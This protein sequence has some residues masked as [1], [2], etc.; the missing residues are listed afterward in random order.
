MVPE[1]I[2]LGHIVSDNGIQVDKLK[3]EVINKLPFTTNQKEIRAFLELA[4]FYRMF[5]RDFAKIA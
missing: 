3:M 4:G 5:I 2:V 1:G